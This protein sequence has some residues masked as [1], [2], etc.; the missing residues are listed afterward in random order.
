M[1]EDLTIDRQRC[2]SP[3]TFF[4]VSTQGD[5][6]MCCDG[7]AANE[8][9]YQRGL[10]EIWNSGAYKNLRCM[11]DTESYDQKCLGCT[12]VQPDIRVKDMLKRHPSLS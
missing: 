11:V 8:N 3:F 10:W 9:I 2:T 1:A 5:I 12:V 4:H 6:C 7:R